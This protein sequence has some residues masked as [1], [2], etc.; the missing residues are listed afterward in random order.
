MQRPEKNLSTILFS[1]TK[2]GNSALIFWIGSLVVF[3]LS[4]YVMKIELGSLI[5][6]KHRGNV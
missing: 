6:R 3:F 2:G 4:V 5:W 1:P